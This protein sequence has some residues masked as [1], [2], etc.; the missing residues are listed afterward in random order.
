ML[1]SQIPAQIIVYNCLGSNLG[2]EQLINLDYLFTTG[3][4]YKKN[5]QFPKS[6]LETRFLVLLFGPCNNTLAS[7]T[8]HFI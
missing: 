6:L 3:F 4:L 7:E 2:S 5:N 8:S 1:E